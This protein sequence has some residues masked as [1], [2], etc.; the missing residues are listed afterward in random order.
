MSRGN[1]LVLTPQLPWPLDD[2]GRLGLH[3]M[4]WSLARAYDTTLLSMVREGGA[5][6][7]P[8]R[9]WQGVPLRVR[10][11]QHT[12][13]PQWQ[14]ALAGSFGRWPYTLARYRSRAYAA[15]IREEVARL[16]PRVVLINHLHLAPYLDDIAAGTTVL[17][18]HNVETRWLERVAEHAPE[19]WVRTFARFQA[20]RMRRTEAELCGRMDLV[21]AIHEQEASLLRSWQP[22]ARVEVVPVGID[23]LRFHPRAPVDPP[24][25]LLTGAFGWGPNAD[26]ARRFLAQGWPR[27]RARFPAARLRLVG[28]GLPDDL[29]ALARESGAEPVG[30]VDDIT[31]EF[32][33]AT[34][35]VVPL[36]V[37]AGMRVKIVEA[38]MAGLPVVSTPLGAEGL[39]FVDGE[40]GALAE[41]APALGNRVADALADPQRR[42]GMAE[43]G[44][45]AAMQRWS[46]AAVADRT[47]EL[48]EQAVVRRAAAARADES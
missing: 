31:P 14:S 46:L 26:G 25:I 9:E 19:P 13:P 36:W 30:Y 5:P 18:E 45:T 43:R 38:A 34:L 32:A 10:A 24:T 17:R 47:V 33:S 29:A 37:G 35:M 21:L 2:G 8:P 39:G 41:E 3:Q 11:V 42:E 22:R 40:H 7:P 27:V 1:A 12:P 28:K 4:T 15:A 20:D 16:A 23:P 6:P 48:I 44:R